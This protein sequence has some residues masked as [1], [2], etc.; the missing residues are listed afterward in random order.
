MKVRK[1][2]KIGFIVV[3]AIVLL[4]FGLNYLKGVYIFSDNRVFYA[5]YP[6]INGLEKSN[7][8]VLNGFQIGQVKEIEI[9]N[10]GTG[11]LL[12][13][14][15]VNK[16][17]EIPADSKALLAAADILGSMQVRIILGSSSELAV[18][19]DTLT[20]EV[21]RDLVEAVNAQL[22][23]IKRK[24]ESLISS[25]DSV[26]RVIEVIL[27]PKSQTNLVESF[28]GINNAVASLER[29]A[30]RIDTL[31]LE[32][33]ERISDILDD[34]NK[35]SSVLSSN[36]SELNNIIKNF[37]QISDTLA[38]A[39]ISETLNQINGALADFEEV[40][41]KINQGEGTLG[42]LINNPDLYNKLESATTNLDLLVED[43]RVNPN[44]Y[45]HFSVFGR[46]DK[47][48]D[49]TRKEL[50]QLQEFIKDSQKN[51]QN[52]PNEE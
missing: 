11:N 30:F 10:D 33:K 7:P 16:N 50:E 12:V 40:M 26:I 32:E 41:T 37:S 48:V 51:A 46:K 4:I 21:E 19:G 45:I 22:A 28:K 9:V 20:P 31:V 15:T 18:P 44:R 39:N 42:M 14:L 49:L 43:I 34:I 8:V 25:V 2:A 29:T 13:T 17:L 36:G 1:E 52:N 27:N 47:S 38:K 3:G 24:A 5:V 35:L 23:P 6:R